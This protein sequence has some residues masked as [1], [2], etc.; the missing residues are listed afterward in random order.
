MFRRPFV[1]AG[2]LAIAS[3]AALAVLAH[4][5]GASCWVVSATTDEVE[6]APTPGFAIGGVRWDPSATARDPAL[7]PFRSDFNAHC[8]GRLGRDAALCVTRHLDD[9]FPWGAPRTDLLAPRFDPA[10]DLAAHLAGEPG[11]CVTRSGITVD[12]LLS[13]GIPA[14]LAQIFPADGA[15]HNIV[16]VWDAETGWTLVDPSFGGVLTSGG[17]PVSAARAITVGGHLQPMGSVVLGGGHYYASVSFRGGAIM[18]P[19]PWLYLR[20]GE[21]IAPRPF[22]GRFARLGGYALRL[23]VGQWLLRL[24]VVLFAFGAAVAF[25]IGVRRR[26]ARPAAAIVP[27]HPA[28]APVEAASTETTTAARR[29]SARW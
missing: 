6:R 27:L 18:Y 11:H 15:A 7:A 2:G 25:V 4:T 10:A 28:T 29:R 3:V 17:R 9:A 23:G 19:E 22:H 24:G 20:S 8:A 1:A 14:R 12:E 13:V 26:R 5:E 21:R 16:E